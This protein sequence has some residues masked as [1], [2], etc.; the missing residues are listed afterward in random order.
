[1]KLLKISELN[2]RLFHDFFIRRNKIEGDYSTAC[3]VGDTTLST[4]ID[5]DSNLLINGSTG[6]IGTEPGIE[7]LTGSTGIVRNNYIVCNLATK[8][9]AVVGDTVMLFENYYNEDITGTGGL[10]GTASADD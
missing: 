7:L 9:A 4:K 3:I 6:N 2:F 5:I 10:I 1:M 8:L